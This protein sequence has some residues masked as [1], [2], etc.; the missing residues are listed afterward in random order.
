MHVCTVALR[1]WLFKFVFRLILKL[2]NQKQYSISNTN[3]S[4]STEAH[5]CSSAKAVTLSNAPNTAPTQKPH[6]PT[7]ANSISTETRYCSGTKAATLSKAPTTTPTKNTRKSTTVAAH[8]SLKPKPRQTSAPVKPPPVAR[9]VNCLTNQS[10]GY[11][12]MQANEETTNDE[13]Y[14][15][16]YEAIDVNM[17]M[18]AEDEYGGE[19]ECI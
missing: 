2:K 13:E 18:N 5:Y 8:A 14:G 3:S 1:T 12:A 19:Y 16:E 10:Y 17:S 11:T 6:K 4:I 9:N 15:G 7:A